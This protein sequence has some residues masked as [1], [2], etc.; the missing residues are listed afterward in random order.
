[1]VK[2]KRSIFFAIMRVMVLFIM[3]LVVA[4]VI[5][6]SQI[7]LETLRGNVLAVLRDATGLPVE[8]D[9]AVS[10]KLSLR[11]QI[12][13]NQVRIPNAD[14]ASH[15]DAFSAKKIDVT[16]D[17][18]SLFQDRPTIQDIKVYDATVCIEQN[19]QGELSIL[20]SILKNSDSGTDNATEKVVTPSDYPFVE[21]GLGGI[22]IQNINLDLLGAKYSING[23]QLRFIPRDDSREY[24]GWV[25]SDTDVFPFIISFSKYNSE[26]KVYPMKI[27]FATGGD[28]LIANV[29]LEGTSKAP[30]DFIVKG[31]IPD[32]AA[33]GDVFNLNL[34][35]MPKMKVDISGGF[36]WQ[37]LTFR[38]S[39]VTV[40]GTQ[41]GFSGGIDWSG[42]KPVFNVNL[43]SK[44]VNLM[45]LFPD[46]YDKSWRRPDREL[47]VF[48]DIPLFG[49]EFLKFNLNLHAMIDSLVV[50]RDIDIKDIDLTVKLTDGVARIDTAVEFAGGDVNA[51]ANVNIGPDGCMYVK[52]GGAGR[53]VVIGTL[54]NQIHISDFISELPMNFDTYV[55]AS[56]STMSEWMQT[57][58]GPV[59]VYSVAPGYAH[60]ALVANMYGTDFLTTLR[61]SIQDLFSSEKKYNQIK[62]SCAVV[63]TKLREGLAETQN[64]VAVE[65]NAIN[66]RL[67]GSL[68]LGKEDI[69]LALTTVPVRG[70]KLSLTGNVVNSIEI[71][72]NLAEPTIR[73]SGAAVAGKV[74]SATGIGLLLAPFTGGI[75]LVA[76]A[77]VGLLAGDLLENWLADDNPCETA[78]ERGAPVRRGDPEWMGRPVA[79]LASEIL[80]N[81]NSQGV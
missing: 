51:A 22:E 57:I 72:G 44:S 30:I 2:K 81:K 1:M 78:L 69:Q 40:R 45:E 58:T 50:Y 29:A 17:L 24:S 25:K 23:F 11:P 49:S 66:I 6:L 63:N 32:I 61:H 55:E 46:L 76:G 68:D 20:S 65:T 48:K 59:Q 14:W 13:L 5:A 62:I 53:N 60:S 47:N 64:G 10:W 67:A 31:D 33:V 39:S 37:K 52:M 42:V 3:G 21:P 75:G 35:S 41:I 74:A 73:I 77:G 4:V 34:A 8:I 54:L 12:E 79:D 7:N 71:T 70:L 38:N 15:D 19:D 43:E 28:A 80:N 16:L 18:I 26:R 9:G 56:G 36:D 27:A